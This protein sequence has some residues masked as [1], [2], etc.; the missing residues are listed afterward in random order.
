MKHACSI[1]AFADFKTGAE[2]KLAMAVVAQ[3]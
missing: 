2:L 3:A 1:D